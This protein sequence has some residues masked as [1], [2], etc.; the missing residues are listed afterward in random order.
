LVS[1]LPALLIVLWMA[2]LA[3][4]GTGQDKPKP[5]DKSKG[6]WQFVE[7]FRNEYAVEK[8]NKARLYEL[9][10]ASRQLTTRVGNLVGPGGNIMKEPVAERTTTW[11]WT[12]LPHV[13]VPGE[14]LP[15]T[16]A[17]TV[18][19]VRGDGPTTTMTAG[20]NRAAQKPAPNDKVDAVNN[21]LSI[22]WG[23]GVE[24]PKGLV[25]LDDGKADPKTLE[26]TVLVPK[27]G[28]ADS[29]K[30]KMVDFAVIV[31]PGFYVATLY[32]YQWVEG[33]PPPADKRGEPVPDP[34]D[35]S[36]TGEK[37][38]DVKGTSPVVPEPASVTKFT[39]QAGVRRVKPG[40]M[41]QVPIYILNPSGVANVNT[42]IAYSPTVATAEG[43]PLRGNVLGSALFE[44]NAAEAGMAR[45]GFAGSKPVTDSGILA[46]VAFKAVGKPGDRTVLKVAVPTANAT[47][48]KPMSAETIDGEVI[49]VGEGGKI[50][51]DYDGDGAVTAGD[52]LSALKMSVKLLAEDKN[53][54]MDKDGSVTSNDARLIL[55]KAVGK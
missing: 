26:G 29:E 19:G 46:H 38:P 9:K 36:T 54:D 7:S 55:L 20:F 8:R 43:K 5:D 41:V 24:G 53:L 22:A 3:S 35:G 11:T 51:G 40:E 14:R 50:P 2:G 49:I 23:N 44:A 39:V 25:R 42:T 21:A 37:P 15:V 1:G 34:S 6:Y 18:R 17:F 52:A 48:G 47:D 10:W 16:L 13:L 4:E 31:G 30:T 28:Y 33:A 12:T 45:V 32:R 27:F